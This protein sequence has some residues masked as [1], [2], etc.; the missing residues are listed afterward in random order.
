MIHSGILKTIP[1]VVVFQLIQQCLVV[2]ADHFQFFYHM[3]PISML[4][5]ILNNSLDL[6]SYRSKVV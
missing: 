6:I 2:L 1:K 3:L 4:E 5:Q